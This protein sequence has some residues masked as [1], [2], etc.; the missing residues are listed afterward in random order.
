MADSVH[1]THR[2]ALETLNDILDDFQ[3]PR[4]TPESG[5]K[6][7][8]KGAIPP[9]EQT[10]SQKMNLSLIGAI[11]SLAN[12]VAA[13]QIFEARKAARQSIEIDLRRSHNYTDPD[14]GMTP[15]L[16]GQEIPMDVLAGNPFLKTI[17]ETKDGKN[18]ILSAVYVDLA[19]QWTALLDCPMTES[20]VREVVERWNAEDLEAAAAKAGLPMAIIHSEESWL[21]TEH[22]SHLAKLPIV[23]IDKVVHHK[24]S[25]DE[26]HFPATYLPASPDRPLSGLKVICMTHAVAGP[27]TGRTLAEHGAS[28]LQV[29]YTHGYEHP[30]VFTYANLG[31]ASTRLNLKKES[32]CRRLR[33]LIKDA[34][35]WVDNFREGGISKF[36]FSDEEIWE[37]NPSMII[38]H[39]RCYGTSGP[40][41]NKP[42]FDM[43]GSASSGMMALMGEGSEDGKPQ[44]PPG[45]VINDYVTGYYSALAIMSVVLR[46]CKGELDPR[47]GCR[48]SP[49]LCSTG[50][51]IMKY[52]KTRDRFP[53]TETPAAVDANNTA[54]GPETIEGDTPWGY[55][56]TLAPLPKMSATPV[57][58]EFGLLDGLGASKPVFPGF[59]DG[60]DTTKIEPNK[61][62]Q[63]F[64][65]NAMGA[66]DRLERLRRFGEEERRRNAGSLEAFITQV[67]DVGKV[68]IPDVQPSTV[69]V[70]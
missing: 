16:N 29:M 19:Y 3:I 30:F 18:V 70:A 36:G 49:S 59:D 69:A 41:K 7:I 28:V 58:Y 1:P 62:D 27:S 20:R 6:I 23:P 54:L 46:R 60:Y 50:M 39:V 13:A 51:S 61:R 40:W 44:W 10:H 4:C 63:W 25:S 8:F 38:D 5:P 15:T 35:V 65:E 11:P 57:R 56:K 33:T 12:A 45:M 43:Q 47:E 22:G 42:G 26:F 17:Y 67:S 2:V 66:I 53:A 24:N 14:L 34:H 55:L 37:A 64:R 68:D 21:S 32:D 9:A 52:F 48:I 31:T